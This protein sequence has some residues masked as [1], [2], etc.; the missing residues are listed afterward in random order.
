M[1][2][3]NIY[4]PEAN[5]FSHLGSEED[6]DSDDLDDEIDDGYGTALLSHTKKYF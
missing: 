5:K 6:D 2:L 3:S 4:K 1:T